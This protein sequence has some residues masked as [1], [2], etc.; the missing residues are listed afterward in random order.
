[1]LEIEKSENVK[2]NRKNV[3]LYKYFFPKRKKILFQKGKKYFSKKE[4]NT[5]L[6]R[7]NTF[8]KRKKILL[9][10][11]KILFQKG[12]KYFSIQRKYVFKK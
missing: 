11:E 4:K 1:M 5:S 8:P 3:Q 10:S 6:F 7:E 9:Y 2:L 12:K